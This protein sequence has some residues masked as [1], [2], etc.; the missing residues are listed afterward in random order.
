MSNL[1]SRVGRERDKI[2]S[3]VEWME[4]PV[5]ASGPAETSNEYQSCVCSVL[6]I[7]FRVNAR[8]GTT[9]GVENS[10]LEY[11]KQVGLDI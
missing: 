11:S 8:S 2:L 9:F 4:L 6:I 7:Y 5:K 3:L 10:T 1:L